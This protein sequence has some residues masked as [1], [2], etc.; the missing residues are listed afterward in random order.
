MEQETVEADEATEASSTSAQARNSAFLT[1]ACLATA[2]IA[3]VMLLV[4]GDSLSRQ[5]NCPGER[6]VTHFLV[7]QA[8]SILTVVLIRVIV[9]CLNVG[10][11]FLFLIKIMLLTTRQEDPYDAC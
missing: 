2:P 11:V 9:H 8:L 4:G 10:S 5:G 3:L 1:L 6:R 7:F